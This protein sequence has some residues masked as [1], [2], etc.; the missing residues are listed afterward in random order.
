MRMETLV[1]RSRIDAPVGR[2][3]AWHAEP[4]ALELLIPPDAPVRIV[5]RRGGISTGAVAVFAIGCGPFR[6]ECVAVHRDCLPD[7]QFRDVQVK[8]PFAHW[9][10]THRFEPDGASASVLEDRVEYALPAGGLGRALAGSVVRRKLE[11]MFD[12]HHAVT[13]REVGCR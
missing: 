3:F 13:I 2:L 11:A 1:R 4:G 12:D 5:Q 8:G 6:I 9:V 7:R 10:H